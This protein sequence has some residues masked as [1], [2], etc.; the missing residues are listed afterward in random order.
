MFPL[1]VPLTRF[2]HGMAPDTMI[3]LLNHWK[4]Q[5][6]S[7]AKEYSLIGGDLFSGFKKSGVYPSHGFFQYENGLWPKLWPRPTGFGH[8]R[9]R[10][11][12]CSEFVSQEFTVICRA[13][14]AGA[15]DQEFP[16]GQEVAGSRY[17]S[18]PS[19]PAIISP[20]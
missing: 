16:G 19:R 6:M 10:S 8:F 14:P 3:R 15:E 12:E 2:F 11:C 13:V 9:A 20:S 18:R 5:A 4:C 17:M 1:T 7:R